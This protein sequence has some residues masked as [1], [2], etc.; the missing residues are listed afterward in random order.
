METL[1]VA[2]ISIKASWLIFVREGLINF[3]LICIVR[4]GIN[5]HSTLRP[6]IAYCAPVPGDYEDG[7]IGGM[8]GKVNRSTRRKP[9]PVPLCPP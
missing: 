8:I 1:R 3:F 5:V 9:A 4:G 6:P 2:A 7:E